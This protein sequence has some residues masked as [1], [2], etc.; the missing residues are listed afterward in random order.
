MCLVL[1]KGQQYLG[2]CVLFWR[3]ELTGKDSHR[4]WLIHQPGRGPEEMK[5]ASEAGNSGSGQWY[6]YRFQDPAGLFG[7]FAQI[8]KKYLSWA[9]EL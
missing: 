7:V 5:K 8:R 3:T 1:G 2:C 6:Q 9:E 4:K